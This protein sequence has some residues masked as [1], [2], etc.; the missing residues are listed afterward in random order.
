MPALLWGPLVGVT[1]AAV[2]EVARQKQPVMARVCLLDAGM[3]ILQLRYYMG[4]DMQKKK[5]KETC[6]GDGIIE[7][8][9]SG[10]TARFST[11]LLNAVFLKSL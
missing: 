11:E 8:A 1:W 5:T 4:E 7:C 6:Q 9:T 2:T 10:V 3:K